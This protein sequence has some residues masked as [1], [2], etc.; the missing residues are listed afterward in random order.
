MVA[1]GRVERLLE[2]IERIDEQGNLMTIAQCHRNEIIGGNLLF[3]SNPCYP[4]TLTATRDTVLLTMGK[5]I[6]FELL[7]QNVLFLRAYLELMHLR[8]PDRLQYRIAVPAE[9]QPQAIG[10]RVAALVPDGACL[11]M[12]IGAI[13]DAALRR[14]FDKHDLGV[15]TEMLSDGVIDL[16]K[17]GVITNRLKAVHPGRVV[18][19]FVI[20]KSLAEKGVEFHIGDAVEAVERRDGHMFSTLKSGGVLE[21]AVEEYF[22]PGP[23]LGGRG[24]GARAGASLS[25]AAWRQ[26]A[27]PGHRVGDADAAL[28]GGENDVQL[29]PFAL[30]LGRV[31][32]TVVITGKHRPTH[33]HCC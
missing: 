1:L 30:V 14:L 3:S 12:G 27:R 21:S 24:P 23:P 26:R 29:A 6:L 19:S 25:P 8:M 31:I 2:R 16:V 13:P 15:H 32:P 28:G 11:Q 18:T 20:E 22:Q 10:E 17:A 7:S 5:D 4:M 9:L 33:P